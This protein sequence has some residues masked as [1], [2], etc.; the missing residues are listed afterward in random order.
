MLGQGNATK[1]KGGFAREHNRTM[2]SLIALPSLKQ[3]LDLKD[4]K[5]YIYEY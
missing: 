2:F 5:M 1:F 4:L 3:K